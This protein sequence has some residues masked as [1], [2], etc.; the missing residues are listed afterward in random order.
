[1]GGGATSAPLLGRPGP[2]PS[3]FGARVVFRLS[4]AALTVDVAIALHDELA[5]RG[6]RVDELRQERDPDGDRDADGELLPRCQ[7]RRVPATGVAVEGRPDV[8]HPH[9]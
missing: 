1:M 3:R 5:G 2:A 6:V 4:I 9:I 7:R 8:V